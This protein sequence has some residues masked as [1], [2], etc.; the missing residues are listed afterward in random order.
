MT[1]GYLDVAGPS[2]YTWMMMSA[3][4]AVTF[5]FWSTLYTPR[6]RAQLEEIRG[7]RA[8]MLHDGLTRAGYAFSSATVSA[9]FQPPTDR[10]GPAVTLSDSVAAMCDRLGIGPAP[11]VRR[12]LLRSLDELA[13]QIQ[14]VHASGAPAVLRHLRQHNYQ[15]GIV[16]NTYFP[17]GR[18]IR[19]VLGADGTLMYF[20]AFAFSDEVGVYKPDPAIFRHVL[21]QLGLD[22]EPKA[23]V[24]VGDHPEIDV[25]GARAAGLRTVRYAGLR[26]RPGSPEA[27]AVIHDFRE[28]PDFIHNWPGADWPVQSPTIGS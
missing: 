6:D 26:D 1:P 14:W 17:P 2:E 20:Q 24:H 8:T 27:D 23:V 16:S 21:Y 19:Q 10:R 11:D 5:D 28:L 13:G 3:V 4:R 9:A 25:A 7:A 15:L 12:R 18:V 22:A